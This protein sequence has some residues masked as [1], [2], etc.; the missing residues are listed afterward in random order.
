[1]FQRSKVGG[2]QACKSKTPIT[3]RKRFSGALDEVGAK[4][5]LISQGKVTI[6]TRM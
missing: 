3:M 2:N 4:F 6:A 1:L 5:S